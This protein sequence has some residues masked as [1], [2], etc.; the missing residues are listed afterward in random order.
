M[1]T[2]SGSEDAAEIGWGVGSVAARL[3]IAASTLRTWER[4][5]DVGPSRR[6]AGGHRRYSE[7]DINRVILTQLL[8]ARGAPARDAARVSHALDAT[9]LANALSAEQERTAREDLSIDQVA[10]TIVDAAKL[11]DSRR[12]A[13]LL[14]DSFDEL[15]A[16]GAWHSV[17]APALVRIGE[18]WS[19]GRLQI[20]AEHIASEVIAAELRAYTRRV[21]DVGL[22][23]PSIVL[24][25][26]EDDQHSLPLFA[27]E[28]ALA[29]VGL[30]TVVL[31]ARMP[32]QS[33]A[34]IAR[35][36][37]PRVVFLW[38]SLPRPPDKPL[39]V[40][41]AALA[42]ETTLILAGPGWSNAA[43]TRAGPPGALDSSDLPSTVERIR[44]LVG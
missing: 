27:M 1:V 39:D 35:Q 43:G 19:A 15:G 23:P 7:T 28:A 12:I 18:E 42:D 9:G 10:P 32:A 26:A 38:A 16:A 30:G 14:A 20:E 22:D 36:L 37:A 8:I 41:L 6:T 4:R 11:G 25:S 17:I 34:G 33:L 13:R 44:A 21:G 40:V 24:A 3:G 29:D 31:G 2:S 5:Y